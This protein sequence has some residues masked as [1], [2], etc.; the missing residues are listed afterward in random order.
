MDPCGTPLHT[1]NANMA[2]YSDGSELKA[3]EARLV[4]PLMLCFDYASF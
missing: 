1:P 4:S 2:D 3:S